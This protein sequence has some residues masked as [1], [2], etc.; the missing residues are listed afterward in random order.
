M[1]S[2]Q[3]VSFPEVPLKAFME[4]VETLKHSLQTAYLIT[5]TSPSNK[6]GALNFLFHK[7]LI[8]NNTVMEK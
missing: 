5:S 3:L 6:S 8:L 4:P 1:K 7:Q 2:L